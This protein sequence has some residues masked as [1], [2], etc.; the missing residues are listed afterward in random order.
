VRVHFR[1]FG[2]WRGR[3]KRDLMGI[4]EKMVSVI[5]TSFR[6]G[7]IAIEPK[8]KKKEKGLRGKME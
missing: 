3:G 7:S 6:T 2:C 4:P 1:M 5:A 8:M